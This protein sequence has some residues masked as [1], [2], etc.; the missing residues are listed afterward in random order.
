VRVLNDMKVSIHVTPAGANAAAA[1]LLAHWLTTPGVR[2]AMLAAGNTPLELYRRIGDRKLSLSHLNVFAL[3]EYVGVPLEEP[4]NCANLIRRTAVQP[5]CIPAS[6]YFTVSSLEADALASV[7]RHEQRIEQV[8]GLDV[9][10]LGLGQNGHLGFNEPGSA[11]GSGARVLDLDP[12]STEANRKWFNGDYAPIR[13]GTVGM[14]TILSA[15][16]VLL[17]A[18]GTHKRTAVE[19]MLRGPRTPAC[20][21]SLL[22]KHPEVHVFLDQAAAKD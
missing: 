6:Q 9:I 7:Q 3:D 21:A 10:V 22:Q 5:W 15:R 12:I 4:R 13:G 17:L 18:F 20:P 16:R 8:G 1:D 19:A 14:K 2:N 11:E